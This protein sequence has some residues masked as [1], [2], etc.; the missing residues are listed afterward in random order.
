MRSAWP[1][2]QAVNSD[3]ENYYLPRFEVIGKL[4]STE[5][6]IYHVTSHFELYRFCAERRGS[7]EDKDQEYAVAELCCAMPVVASDR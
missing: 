1:E 6:Q 4:P 3:S 7:E 2:S 5:C